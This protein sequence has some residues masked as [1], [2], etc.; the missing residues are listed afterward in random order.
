MQLGSGS[1]AA[2]ISCETQ[3]RIHLHR[4]QG[5]MPNTLRKATPRT[6]SL[7]VASTTLRPEPVWAMV[8]SSSQASSRPR[9]TSVV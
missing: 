7:E 6:H 9:S 4:E 1:S 5:Q 2:Q 3:R 8:G